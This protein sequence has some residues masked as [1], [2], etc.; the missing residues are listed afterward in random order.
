M[1]NNSSSKRWDSDKYDFLSF[2]VPSSVYDSIVSSAFASGKSINSFI[3]DSILSYL[4]LDEWPVA[5][6]HRSIFDRTPSSACVVCGKPLPEGKM[7]YCSA[8]CKLEAN[9]RSN[10]ER[11]RRVNLH[12][13]SED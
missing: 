13:T 10:R 11:M 1:N 12:H 5:S 7:R 9:R 3:C 6:T 4:G 2:C 8:E